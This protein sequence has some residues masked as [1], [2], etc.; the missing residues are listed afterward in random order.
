MGLL[1]A[2]DFDEQYDT[3]KPKTTLA[4]GMTLPKEELMSYQIMNRMIFKCFDS[5][6]GNFDNKIIDLI[7][8]KCIEECGSNLMHLPQMYQKAHGFK[9]FAEPKD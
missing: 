7:E 1:D 9:V 2:P 4:E 3:D 8:K 6:V 5:C